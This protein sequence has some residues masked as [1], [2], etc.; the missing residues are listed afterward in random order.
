MSAP[1]V[2][3]MERVLTTLGFREPDRVPLF[4]LVTMHGARA[5]GL[6][7]QE[8]YS[9]A[10]HVVEGQLRMRARYGHDCLSPFAHASLEVE[11]WGGETVFSE[12]GPPNAGAPFIRPEH[13]PA[14]TPPRIADAR[15]LLRL[16]DATRQLKARSGGDV[17]I[18]G[19]VMSPFSLP[20]MQMGFEGYLDLLIERRDLWERLMAANEAFCVEW[21]NAQLEAGATAICYFDPVA[22]PTIVPRELYLET[23]HRV[24]TRTVA[25][26]KGPTATHLASGIALP[27]MDDLVATGTAV[28]GVSAQEDL[29]ALKDAARGRISL[30]GNLNGIEMCRWSAHDAEA[31]VKD[32]ISKAGRGG[33]FMLSDNHGEIPWQVSEE[34]LDA[35]A[36]AAREWGRYPIRGSAV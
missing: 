4:L 15:G 17:P 27:I 18:I 28:A 12:D 10:D 2:T 9:K 33:G 34:T 32:A 35:I 5:L 8:Y 14:L 6:S 16:L 7:I 11:A 19:V 31:A 26:I 22:S 36:A 3:S 23:G 20:V 21:A 13:I 30:L 24:A 29:G 25:R 1:A